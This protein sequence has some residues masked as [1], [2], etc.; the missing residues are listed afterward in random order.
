MS[1]INEQLT[2]SFGPSERQASFLSLGS[3]PLAQQ[4][5]RVFYQWMR[6]EQMD[7]WIH[8][9]GLGCVLLL[10]I[11]YIVFWYRRDWKELPKGVGWTLL[12]LRLLAIGGILFFFLDL[13]KR[14]EKEVVRASKL[15]VLVD[16]SLSMTMPQEDSINPTEIIDTSASRIAAVQNLFKESSLLQDFQQQHDVSVYRFDQSVRPSLVA[17]FLKPQKTPEGQR[18]TRL[19]VWRTARSVALAGSVLGMVALVGFVFALASRV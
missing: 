16:T 3:W 11:S 10:L 19:D 7:Q 14:S 6:I 2:M 15:A 8:W 17:S 5:S 9:F 4:D 18:D 12:L 13:Q 1:S